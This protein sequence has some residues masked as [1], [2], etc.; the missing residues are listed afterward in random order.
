MTNVLPSF[1]SLQ[2]F[3]KQL[4]GFSGEN[5]AANFVVKS[6]NFYVQNF[7]LS[8]FSLMSLNT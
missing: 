1:F 8:G 5:I 3:T 7:L 2:N 4:A 6:I